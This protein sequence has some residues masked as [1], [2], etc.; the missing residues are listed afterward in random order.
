[1]FCTVRRLIGLAF[2]VIFAF[3]ACGG[4]G[5]QG[6]SGSLPP[7]PLFVSAQRGSDSNL[8][9]HDHP[10]RTISD[11]ARLALDHYTIYVGPG[12]YVEPQGVT[13]NR[14][15][16]VPQGVAFIADPSGILTGDSVARPVLLDV[17][18]GAGA[19]FNLSS[20]AGCTSPTDLSCGI[21]DGFEIK[22]AHD[23][24]IVIKSGSNGFIIQ[25][26]VIHDGAGDGIR[27]QDSA[28]VV[29]FNNLAY[30]T[31]GDGISIAGKVAGSRNATVVNNTVF[32]AQ[33]YGFAIGTTDAASTGAF[34][35]NNILQHNGL[36]PQ[37]DGNIKVTSTQTARSEVGYSG[38]FNLVFDPTTYIEPTGLQHPDDV[39]QEARFINAGADFHL[40]GSSPAIDA[41]GS[42]STVKTIIV[43]GLG[44]Q[45]QSVQVSQIL[46]TRTTGAGVADT[47]A[48]DL[49]YH[50]PL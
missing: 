14:T 37:I 18:A 20:T 11:A 36:L 28:N 49:G 45:R 10:L 24:G 17:S 2:G 44:A 34:V 16:V 50:Y 4:G 39:N 41:G 23:A 27:V 29:V 9:D 32:G 12:T 30:N 1:M 26:C 38:D 15:G 3:G 8:G 13:T 7:N 48:R 19:G 21:I 43:I 46:S 5:G 35:H 6:G 40:L 42:L 25:N 31:G 33:S 47:N 22:G